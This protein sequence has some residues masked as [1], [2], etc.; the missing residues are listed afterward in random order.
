MRQLKSNLNF[1]W[2][3]G[4]EFEGFILLIC[5]PYDFRLI[6]VIF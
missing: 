2:V 3:Y 4:L 5:M 1:S 6:I